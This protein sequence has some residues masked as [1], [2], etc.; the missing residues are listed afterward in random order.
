M[1]ISIDT[2][3][4]GSRH[5]DIY[6][7]TN[8]TEPIKTYSSSRGYLTSS[9][10]L[11]DSSCSLEAEVG[12]I[13][14]QG[15]IAGFNL[16]LLR[17]VSQPD[18]SLQFDSLL[19]TNYGAGGTISSR[20]LSSEEKSCGCISNAVDGTATPWPKVVHATEEFS[21]LLYSLPP[22]VS[23]AELTDKLFEILRPVSRFYKIIL[24]Q[25]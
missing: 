4:L 12:R 1:P 6:D 19:V 20:P 17:P 25:C 23:E 13:I 24:H 15:A 14:P 16:L 18:G 8:I 10:L 21:R 5:I 2:C 22:S 11:S 7:R 9:F 3:I